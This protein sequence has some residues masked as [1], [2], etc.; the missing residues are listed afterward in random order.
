MRTDIRCHEKINHKHS[1]VDMLYP[2]A[3]ATRFWSIVLEAFDWSFSLPT[4]IS[5]LLY[6]VLVGHPFHASERISGLPLFGLSSGL[7]GVITTVVSSKTC[8][9]HLIVYEFYFI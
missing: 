2:E 6:V 4:T 9:F 3:F 7:F 5:E 8:F 1:Y